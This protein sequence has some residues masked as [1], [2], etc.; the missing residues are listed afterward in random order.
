V[1]RQPQLWPEVTPPYVP[2][3]PE[4][5]ARRRRPRGAERDRPITAPAKG[6]LGLLLAR[7]EPDAPVPE[8]FGDAYD[9]L[10]KHGMG[11]FG[12]RD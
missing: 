5:A 2:T 3:N 4:A 6:L 8:T 10:T 7:Y 1:P 9:V 11:L 12:D